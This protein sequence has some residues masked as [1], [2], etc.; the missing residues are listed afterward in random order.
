MLNGRGWKKAAD[1]HSGPKYYFS[2]IVFGRRKTLSLQIQKLMTKYEMIFV[3]G[4]KIAISPHS[5][6]GRS[7]H[8]KFPSTCL[9]TGP[10]KF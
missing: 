1:A 5:P 9:M 4:Y 7:A 3:T 2:C 8:N 6:H 10:N